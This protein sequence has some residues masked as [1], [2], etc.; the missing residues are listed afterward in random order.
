MDVDIAGES[1]EKAW[2]EDKNTLKYSNSTNNP[3]LLYVPQDV[4]NTDLRKLPS[5]IRLEI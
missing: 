1:N 3:T 4:L 5:Q 2:E